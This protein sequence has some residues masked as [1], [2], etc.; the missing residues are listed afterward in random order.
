SSS[1]TWRMILASLSFLHARAK[2]WR[3]A[4]SRAT[5]SSSPASRRAL[6]RSRCLMLTPE[7]DQAITS[8][9]SLVLGV[10]AHRPMGFGLVVVDMGLSPSFEWKGGE[11]ER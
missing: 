7:Q 9:K 11:A 4:S 8:P 6:I 5:P 1:L 2:A 10:T 3:G